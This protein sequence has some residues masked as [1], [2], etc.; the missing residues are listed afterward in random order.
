MKKSITYLLLSFA[1]IASLVACSDDE[2]A[3]VQGIKGDFAYI[4]GGTEAMYQATE[5]QIY[6]TPDLEDGS[7]DMSFTLALTK[8]QRS[9]VQLAVSLDNSLVQDGYEAFPDGMIEFPTT[10]T[11]PAGETKQTVSFAIANNEFAKLTA[12]T[13]MAPI[14]LTGATGVQVSTNSNTAYLIV[15]ATT[16]NP[17]D[18]LV[19]IANSTDN[20]LVKNYIDGTTGDSI[21]KTLTITGTDAAYKDFS[22]TLA[23]D[24]SYVTN[25]NAVNGTSLLPLP[26]DVAISIPTAV[27]SEGAT[28]TQVTVMIPDA[29]RSKL[30]DANGYLIPIVVKDAGTATVG[31]SGVAYLVIEVRNFDSSS[32]FFSTLYLGDYRM[33]TW[34]QFAKPIEFSNGYTYV[35]H[36]FIDEVTDHARIGDFADINENWINMLRFGQKGNKDTRLEWF[37]GPNGCRQKLYTS[38]LEAQTWYQ[39][40]LV[41]TKD[42]YQLYVEGVLQDEYTLTDD[43]KTKMASLVAP[44]FQAIEFNSSWGANYRNGD[45]FHGRLWEMAIF[46]LALDSD[47]LKQYCYHT[48]PEWL[49]R[50]YASA[51]WPFDEGVGHICNETSGKYESIDFSKTVRCDDESSMT[52]ADVSDYVGWKADQYNS[53]D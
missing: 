49:I 35:F 19:I 53:F 3:D 25:Y 18:N 24:D 48:Y 51:H 47:D 50:N 14:H 10:V 45:E 46:P 21:S 30:T 41:Y 29:E 5:C 31:N 9:D 23:V 7:I 42:S 39:I 12:P 28:S 20:Y 16:I 4:V 52:A 38:A 43:D 34:Y 36:C 13:Y 8:A 1:A 37:V 44:A 11:I 40:G 6:H 22:I 27:M 32:N 17:A 15:N 33:A 2:T 26:S